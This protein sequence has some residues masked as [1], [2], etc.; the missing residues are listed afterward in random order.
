MS[1]TRKRR[2]LKKLH[3]DEFT[4]YGFEVSYETPQ[5]LEFDFLAAL[6]KD[7]L[8]PRNIVFVYEEPGRIFVSGLNGSLSNEVREEVDSWLREAES[9][10]TCHVGP[11]VDAWHPPRG[12]RCF[13]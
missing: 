6:S 3:L 10:P 13:L 9:S 1:R 12:A 7:L 2:L 8:A 5:V 11:L 4:E